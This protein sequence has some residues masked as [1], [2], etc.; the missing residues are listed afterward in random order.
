M[1]S[2]FSSDLL[3]NQKESPGL[4][5]SNTIVFHRT[6]STTS[7]RNMKLKP[8]LDISRLCHLRTSGLS[9]STASGIQ[10]PFGDTNRTQNVSK[11][12]SE[13]QQFR[14]LSYSAAVQKRNDY[15]YKEPLVLGEL[16]PF[17]SAEE[18]ISEGKQIP[19]QST[20]G[21]EIED[22]EVF[23]MLLY[24]GAGDV[25]KSSWIDA[26]QP[27]V[28]KD[29]NA[30]STLF[31]YKCGG[32]HKPEHCTEKVRLQNS[33][34]KVLSKMRKADFKKRGMPQI[35]SLDKKEDDSKQ[36]RRKIPQSITLRNYA[37][38]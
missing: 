12:R 34:A 29:W 2:Y 8:L 1:Y 6:F 33:V 18:A 16:P 32:T 7:T 28:S 4:E 31:C 26:S 13:C 5:F 19:K 38:E 22:E 11:S 10:K 15:T 20:E 21:I 14:Q 24:K 35:S 30:E 23:D 37:E 3:H 36:R 27:V 9:S 25:R 17:R